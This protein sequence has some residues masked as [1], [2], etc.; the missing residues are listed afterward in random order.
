MGSGSS[1]SLDAKRLIE[2]MEMGIE[3]CRVEMGGTGWQVGGAGRQ[4][5][6]VGG[7]GDTASV[8]GEMHRFRW[9]LGVSIGLDGSAISPLC[10]I[11]CR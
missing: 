2:E 1:T 7:A 4:W 10:K 5:V 11:H 3:W 6:P 9:H 8:S